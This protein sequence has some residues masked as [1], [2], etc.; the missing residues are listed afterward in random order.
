[1]ENG[2]VEELT[3]SFLPGI[4]PGSLNFDLIE[5][6]GSGRLFFRV[7]EPHSGQS[8][9]AM[10][11]S[12]D[13]PDNAR[14]ASITDFLIN[15]GVAVPEIVGRME[16]VGYLLVE[17]LGSTDLGDYAG[18]DWETVQK[19][20][21]EKALGTV[22][23][24]HQISEDSHP[25]D[26]PELEFCFDA[27]LY[28]WEQDYFFKQYVTRFE[29]Q[30][31]LAMRHHEA[32]S[33]IRDQLSA[34]PRSLVHRDFQSTNVMLKDQ[35]CYLIDYQGM[36]FGLPEYDVASMIYDPYVH[37]TED[38]RKEL[39]DYYYGL[40]VA[41]GHPESFAEY[42]KR[43]DTCAMQRLMQALGAYGFLGTVKEK[44]EFL[45]HI[46]PARARLKSVAERRCE[47]LYDM[48]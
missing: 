35:R 41:A 5:K 7:S 8:W 14:F 39:I 3:Y 34:L 12:D 30:Q 36:R 18:Q 33:T 29:S 21:Y 6:G 9:V 27:K 20:G 2:R 10:A 13:R 31:A 16:E 28:Q 38:Q 45:K 15:H 19:P 17:D 40:K 1:M 25:E 32:F 22:F 26:L 24:L 48:L 42:E 4:S 43:L 46:E 37:L 44:T 23:V 47:V 11:Y